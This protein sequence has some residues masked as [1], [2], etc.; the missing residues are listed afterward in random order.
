MSL[1][2]NMVIAAIVGLVS[3]LLLTGL[4]ILTNKAI[5][6]T[7]AQVRLIRVWQFIRVACAFAICGLI[8]AVVMQA[9][10]LWIT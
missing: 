5:S 8:G 10:G 7:R 9:F 2:V 6:Y 4:I 1:L 3:I